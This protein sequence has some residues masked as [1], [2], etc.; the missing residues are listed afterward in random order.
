[1]AAGASQPFFLGVGNKPTDMQA[2]E[3]VGIAKNATLLIN[4]RSHLVPQGALGH[5]KPSGAAGSAAKKG[6]TWE[7]VL[8]SLQ[9][10]ITYSDPALIA[11][12]EDLSGSS[13]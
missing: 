11:Y 1:V 10:Y 2:Y 6:T 5:E 12:L 8:P 13:S 3:K 9:V 7:E 4:P